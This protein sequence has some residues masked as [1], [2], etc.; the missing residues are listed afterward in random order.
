[1]V[2]LIHFHNFGVC[3]YC[4]FLCRIGS[5]HNIT[6]TGKIV[7]DIVNSGE[8]TDRREIEYKCYNYAH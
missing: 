7:E 4:L 5:E 8:F 2:S 6:V 3:D 1:M